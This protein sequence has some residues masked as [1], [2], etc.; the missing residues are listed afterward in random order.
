[1]LNPENNKQNQK[2]THRMLSNA[3]K[4]Q[5]RDLYQQKME[6]KNEIPK[7]HYTIAFDIA[8]TNDLDLAKEKMFDHLNGNLHLI[9][10]AMYEPLIKFELLRVSE[11]GTSVE[12]E[13]IIE[14]KQVEI[15]F[16]DVEGYEEESDNLNF[17][18]YINKTIK[19][20]GVDVQNIEITQL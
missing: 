20:E 10:E 13:I 12:Y 15:D 19:S 16:E 1:M 11:H 17:Q 14:G 3:E 5:I 6:Q 18:D 8:N 7:E 9:A 4:Q 2:I